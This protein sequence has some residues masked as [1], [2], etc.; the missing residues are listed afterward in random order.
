VYAE[1]EMAMLEELYRSRQ[2]IFDNLGRLPDIEKSLN[3]MSKHQYDLSEIKELSKAV[4]ELVEQ[5]NENAS[6]RVINWHAIQNLFRRNNSNY[7]EEIN[8]K[9]Q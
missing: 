4:K 3:K 8:E 6:T 2:A 5:I 7:I 9:S 1:N